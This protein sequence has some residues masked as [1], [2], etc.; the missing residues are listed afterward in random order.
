MS[1]WFSS[2]IILAVLDEDMH[3]VRPVVVL[4]PQDVSS[5]AFDCQIATSDYH[6][7]GPEDPRLLATA[8]SDEVFVVWSG[9]KQGALLNTPC[10]AK[11]GQRMYM[12]RIGSDLRLQN[13]SPILAHGD[14]ALAL[15]EVE[16]NWSPFTYTS[17]WTGRENTLIEISI[18]PHV[19]ANVSYSNGAPLLG[20]TWNTSSGVVGTW[21]EKYSSKMI[22]GDRLVHGGVSPIRYQ[23]HGQDVFVSILHTRVNECN[24]SSFYLSDNDKEYK[25]ALY[26]FEASPP[27]KILGVGERWLPL[28]PKRVTW[29]TKVAFA[30]QLLGPTSTQ[31]AEFWVMY[32]Q[33]DCQSQ[34]LRL[35]VTEFA[36][37]L[38]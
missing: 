28:M 33:G 31:A 10:A 15:H 18:S 2:Y 22:S 30:T 27:F 17:N 37:Y 4:G 24:A 21:M 35:N 34:R 11:G 25:S 19:V 1:T 38:P 9:R 12:S 23:H 5:K 14:A 20:E 32:G 13:P 16:K 26:I 6:N 36:S 3:P 8:S 29:S 7:F